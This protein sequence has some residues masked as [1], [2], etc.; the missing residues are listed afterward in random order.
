M[1]KVAL[2]LFLLLC[3][4]LS[5]KDVVKPEARFETIEAIPLLGIQFENAMETQ[6]MENIWQVW[7]SLRPQLPDCAKGPE[8]GVFF[9]G[10]N[11]DPEAETGYYYMVGRQLDSSDSAPEGWL[12]HIIPGGDYA[13][14]NYT[15][16][17][18]DKERTYNYIY[19]EW[20]PANK[21]VP[22]MQ[23]SFELYKKEYQPGAEEIHIEIWIPLQV[24]TNGE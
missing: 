6:T 16:S 1:R 11:F 24:K 5:A 2:L 19:G 15:G 14:F 12:C 3:F 9:Y 10:D 20:I 22:L 17:L 7:S 13:V 18:S 21:A 8:Y 23:D 4:G